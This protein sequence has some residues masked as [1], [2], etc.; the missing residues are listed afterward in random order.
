MRTAVI[1]SVSPEA[2]P[3]R[4]RRRVPE[5][6]LVTAAAVLL[7]VVM[8]WPLA[9]RLSRMGRVDSTDAM[10]AMWNVA[11]VARALTTN[12]AGVFDANIF[13][14][15]RQ[16][17]AY[18]ESN[19]LTG[20]LGIPAWLI[21]KNVYAT[22]NAVTLLGF[23]LSF[24]C[25]YALARRL[26]GSWIGAA[27]AGIG[28]AFCPYVYARFPHIQLQ[29]TFGM[30]LSLLALHALVDRPTWRRGIALGAALAV[31]GLTCAYYGI[32]AGLLVGL[33]VLLYA[34]FR[35]LWA[36]QAYWVAV[37]TALA[38]CLVLIVPMFIPYLTLHE[39]G[40]QRTLEEAARYSFGWQ[41]WLASAVRA[42][43]W[44]LPWLQAHG[45]RGGVLFPG[46][47]TAILG[48][49]GIVIAI[50]G[51][52]GTPAAARQHAI[53]YGVIGAIALWL[54][55]GPNA[56]LYTLLYHTLPV[57]RLLRAPERFGIAVT[58]ALAIG[59]GF[60]AAWI[61]GRLRE[62][63]TRA[64]VAAAA[65]LLLAA[66]IA[67]KWIAPL[68]FREALPVPSPYYMLARAPRGPVAEFPYFTRSIDL[69]RY[70]EYMFFSTYHWQPLVN[71]YSDHMPKDFL[72][73]VEEISRFPTRRAFTL[74]R[75]R[76]TRYVLVHLNYYHHLRRPQVEQGLAHY[77]AEGVL[78]FLARDGD[79]V[80]YQVV[81]YP[82]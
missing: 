56:G 40:F 34:A 4:V 18:S 64:A 23:M 72:D 81:R 37:A 19:L 51:G 82:N 3:A 13:F 16:T 33:G 80:L 27:V 36:E 47:V 1:H 2:S 67:D 25:A 32:L 60:A 70:A 54:S 43:A 61:A 68:R 59:S 21:T 17:L 39:S 15:H 8:T 24:L 76:G 38:T 57:F 31:Q 73:T 5:W 35:R 52:R 55:L 26:T 69:N 7:A 44:M 28:F 48:L 53:F 14:P 71:G 29:M 6:A 65:S 30:P 20:A 22:Y 10:Y 77:T 78:R 50:R 45:W 58:L 63:R 9:P 11:W 49:A 62:S 41:A 79:V 42:H 66:S 75:D 46:F 74:L 12:P